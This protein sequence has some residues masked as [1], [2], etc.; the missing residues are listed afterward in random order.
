ML[1]KFSFLVE[2]PKKVKI[3]KINKINKNNDLISAVS[4]ELSDSD[5]FYKQLTQALYYAYA[6]L[7]IDRQ[8]RG[9][10]ST[11]FSRND[12]KKYKRDEDP[13]VSMIERRLHGWGRVAKILPIE[14]I[15]GMK[16]L[17]SPR[18]GNNS[19]LSYSKFYDILDNIAVSHNKDSILEVTAR[20]YRKYATENNIPDW[21]TFAGR[22]G[23]STWRE[24]I[25]FA[26]KQHKKDNKDE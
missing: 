23:T 1:V 25:L 18:K 12:Y 2:Y 4:G 20:E 7:L 19:D 22:M 13:S 11:S 24:S 17:R 3:I 5:S 8:D 9:D 6:N 21:R 14:N 26:Y 10:L 15:E 16:H